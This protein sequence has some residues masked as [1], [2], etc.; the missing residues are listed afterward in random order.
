MKTLKKVAFG[1]LAVVV[2]LVLIGF[3]LPASYRVERSVVVQAKPD[4]IFPYVNTLK[5]WPE[6]SAWNVEKYPSLTYHY[7]GP[8]AGPGATSEWTSKDAGSGKL[9]VTSATVPTRLEYDL[10]FEQ[11]KYQSKGTFTFEERT[12]GTKVV[13]ADAGNM[14][15]SPLNRWFGLLMDKFM[16]PDFEAG[17]AKLKSVAEAKKP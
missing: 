11:G 7:S 16:G 13:W 5:K 8:E 4:A 9:V 10:S 1:L 3:L 6:W 14:G 2:L 15:W 17:L 12:E